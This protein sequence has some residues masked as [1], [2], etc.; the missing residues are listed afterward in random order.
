MISQNVMSP[1]QCGVRKSELVTTDLFHQRYDLVLTGTPKYLKVCLK[2]NICLVTV[3][4]ATN[5]EPYVAVSTVACLLEN[6]SMGVWFAKCRQ[7][8]SDLP[9]AR[10]RSRFCIY[11]GSGSDSFP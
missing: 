1:S 2:S 3:L 8:V 11:C 7:R 9:V 5:S 6:E 4:N 10:Q